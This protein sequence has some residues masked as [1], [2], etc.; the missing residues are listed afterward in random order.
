V[1]PGAQLGRSLPNMAMLELIRRMNCEREAAGLPRWTDAEGNDI[2]PHG[3]RSCFK[4]WAT[5]WAPS[6][7]EIVDAAKRGELVE[8]FP[9]D[10]VEVALAHALDS[11]VEEA[12]RRTE[13]I[14]ERRRVMSRW[15]D[16][17]SRPATAGDVVPSHRER[18]EAWPKARR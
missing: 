8:A 12:H 2:V 14:E 10:L 13:M 3:F 16:W 18:G 1:F 17:C 11:E 15:V 7:A 6:P 5:D 4:D 9:R